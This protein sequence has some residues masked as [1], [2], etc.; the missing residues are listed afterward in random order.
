[1]PPAGVLGPHGAAQPEQ[2]QRASERAGSMH[3]QQHGR[4]G[5]GASGAQEPLR[6]A[7]PSEQPPALSSPP[8]GARPARRPR[9]DRA[10]GL[11]MG[12]V[13]SL[14]ACPHG[15]R[16]CAVPHA[17]SAPL[18]LAWQGGVAPLRRQGWGRPARGGHIGR[19]GWRGPRPRSP[20]PRVSALPHEGAQP[21]SCS[22]LPPPPPP[23][24]CTRLTRGCNPALPP[25]LEGLLAWL[26][27][28]SIKAHHC[29]HPTCTQD[30]P[31]QQ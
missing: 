2:L 23:T 27:A 14:G 15:L 7:T 28:T 5:F 20:R 30:L 9:S 10:L 19:H 16:H 29:L 12:L 3:R 11:E 17:R 21:A 8:A 6:A 4:A 13:P 22:P 24:A 31:G 26:P 1:M 25:C 18:T